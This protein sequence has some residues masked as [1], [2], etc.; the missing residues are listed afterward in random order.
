MAR[1]VAPRT[2]RARKSSPRRAA[3]AKKGP[4]AKPTVRSADVEM[5]LP[6]ERLDEFI[7][8]IR[9]TGKFTLKVRYAGTTP[10]PP[11]V[12]SVVDAEN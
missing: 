11:E 3:S 5:A 7:D 9:R 4:S 6:K 2:K 8:C 12:L 1:T 10:I